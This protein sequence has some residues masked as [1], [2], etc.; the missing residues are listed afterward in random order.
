[1][2]LVAA[3]ASGQS[4]SEMSLAEQKALY[5]R[6]TGPN[7]CDENAFSDPLCVHKAEEIRA[8]AHRNANPW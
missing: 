2:A 5:E 7:Y 4:V 8:E 1:M 3:V 6:L